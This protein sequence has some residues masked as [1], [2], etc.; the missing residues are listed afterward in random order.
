MRWTST[1]FKSLLPGRL[2]NGPKEELPWF[3]RRKR[4]E[5]E[6]EKQGN[7]VTR[8]CVDGASARE[9]LPMGMKSHSEK[10]QE[11]S[12]DDGGGYLTVD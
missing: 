5:G 3:K 8:G 6:K 11:P 10:T 9:S 12:P 1:R 4:K 2:Q 7:L